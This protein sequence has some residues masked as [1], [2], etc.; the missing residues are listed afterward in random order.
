MLSFRICFLFIKFTI[1]F[2]TQKTFFSISLRFVVLSFLIF[3]QNLLFRRD[4]DN[5]SHRAGLQHTWSKRILWNLS[6]SGAFKIVLFNL[7][8]KITHKHF[9]FSQFSPNMEAQ[10]ASSI[11]Q[12]SQVN[13]SPSFKFLFS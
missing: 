8:F 11:P 3:H 7:F 4:S 2:S 10:G 1:S 5:I 13:N 12:P 6:C 9:Q